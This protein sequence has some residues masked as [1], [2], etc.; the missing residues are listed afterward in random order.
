M[1]IAYSRI[2]FL[3]S[4]TYPEPFE[5]LVKYSREIPAHGLG[6]SRGGG[7]Y[8]LM[9]PCSIIILQCTM[10]IVDSD[11]QRQTLVVYYYYIYG[12]DDDRHKSTES[13]CY[14]FIF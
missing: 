10:S 14:Y 5:I 1:A 12:A 3:I 4:G 2:I 6:G 7:G 9:L 11:P 13:F 8:S